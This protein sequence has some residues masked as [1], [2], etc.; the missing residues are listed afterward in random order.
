MFPEETKV[1]ILEEFAMS[2]K[3]SGHRESFRQNIVKAVVCKYT[4]DLKAHMEG[5]RPLYRAKQERRSRPKYQR[6]K[7]S[8]L[9]KMGYN[10]LLMLPATPNSKLL[11]EVN[12]KLHNMDEPEK[13]KTYITEDYGVASK[14]MLCRSD[15]FPRRRCGDSM[16]LMC[17]NSDDAGTKCHVSN[18]GY[19]ISCKVCHKVYIGTTSRNCKTRSAEHL[20]KRNS[21]INRH[22]TV[23]HPGSRT[24]VADMYKMEVTGRFKD[25]M[26]RQVDEAVK[27]S[28]AVRRQ[29]DIL[30][31]KKEFS[32]LRLVALSANYEE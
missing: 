32:V 25:A 6:S 8:W 30:N 11:K 2:M 21:T 1:K 7:V 13:I 31:E 16:C 4:D 22:A 23:Q 19:K 9:H 26:S 27:I 10:N 24:E 5:T 18:V 28:R 15:P 20:K 3:C 14:Q 12:S 29:E 17:K